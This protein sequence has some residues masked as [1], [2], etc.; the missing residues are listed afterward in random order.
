MAGERSKAQ[1]STP[2]VSSN[3]QRGSCGLQAMQGGVGALGLRG[4]E[5]AQI[6]D[7]LRLLGYNVGAGAA[8][9]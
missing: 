7:D 6:H 3:E 8:V 5:E 9:R 1:R 2:P 4:G